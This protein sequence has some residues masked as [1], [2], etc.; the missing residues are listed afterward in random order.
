MYTHT[1]RTSRPSAS[2]GTL[3]ISDRLGQAFQSI[4]KLKVGIDS[5]AIQL[6]HCIVL[7]VS[8]NTGMFSSGSEGGDISKALHR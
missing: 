1:T 6:K 4:P 5:L 7:I 3:G 2:L 8:E